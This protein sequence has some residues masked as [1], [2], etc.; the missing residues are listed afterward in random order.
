MAGISH[1]NRAFV[2]KFYQPSPWPGSQAR[3]GLV[4]AQPILKDLGDIID[5]I[6]GIGTRCLDPRIR[7]GH[8]S[9]TFGLHSHKPRQNNQTATQVAAKRSYALFG[10]ARR[11]FLRGLLA[12]GVLIACIVVSARVVLE[13]PEEPAYA[14]NPEDARPKHFSLTTLAKAPISL[15]NPAAA[16]SLRIRLRRLPHSDIIPDT[17]YSYKVRVQRGDTLSG[18]LIRTGFK[19]DETQAAMAA[20]RTRYNPRLIDPGQ[21]IQVTFL[22]KVTGRNVGTLLGLS[23][24]PDYKRD[25]VVRRLQSGDFAASI[26]KKTFKRRFA[27]NEGTIRHSLFVAGKRSRVPTPILAELIRA[28]S[29]DIDFQREIRKGDSFEVLYEKYY[30]DYGNAVFT[31][32]IQFAILNVNGKPLKIYRHTT[33]DGTTDYFNENGKSARK[34]LMR[35]PIDGA[36]LS[37][38]FGRRRHPI[39]GYNKMHRGVDFA[40][41][42][43]TP[44]YAAGDGVITKIGWNGAYGRYIRIRHNRTHSTAYA[45]MHRF[46]RGLKRGRRV[47]QGQVIGYVGSTGRSTGPHLHYEI[48]KSGRRVNPMRIRMPSGRQLAGPELKR[49]KNVKALVKRRLNYLRLQSKYASRSR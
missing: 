30:D 18:L 16:A 45:H 44:I 12:A 27:H 28:Y 37:S 7:D 4:R 29:W 36:R 24:T 20:L 49:F 26:H 10:K 42:R 1:V 15:G 33:K 25:I 11:M 2:T 22:P 43:G 46:K 31:G 38:G 21:E 34:A 6:D 17:P 41:S 19:H 3:A 48:L 23:V 32:K 5:S 40:A 9:D 39:L 13:F 8:F 14:G 47:K 35:T